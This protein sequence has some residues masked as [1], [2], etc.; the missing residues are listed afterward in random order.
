LA[1]EAEALAAKLQSAGK[2]VLLKRFDGVS[3]GWD[4]TKVDESN[5]ARVRD[6]AYGLVVSYLSGLDKTGPLSG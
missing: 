6:E 1:P 3:H 4:K 5:N 2:N